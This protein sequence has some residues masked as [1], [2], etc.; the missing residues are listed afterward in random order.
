MGY[1]LW[2]LKESDMTE[3][4]CKM[5][6]EGATAQCLGSKPSTALTSPLGWG[7]WQGTRCLFLSVGP[8]ASGTWAGGKMQAGL[9]PRTLSLHR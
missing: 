5:G 4:L 7:S 2:G 9:S 8:A 3:Q 1:S 6:S